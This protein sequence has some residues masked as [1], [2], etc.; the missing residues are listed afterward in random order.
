MVQAVRG[1][2]GIRATARAFRVAVST[3]QYWVARSAGQ[4]LDRV[5]FD[6]R[7][8]GRAVNRTP[9]RIE[10]HVLALREQLRRH[11]VLGEYGARA[12]GAALQEGRTTA[13]VPARATIHRIL[14]RHGALDGTHRQRR[15]PPPKGWYLPAVAAGRAELDSFDFIEDLKIAEGPLVSVL[16][17]TSLHGAV[18]GA[19]VMEQPSAQ[20]TVNTL[21]DRWRHLGL[22]SYAQFDNDTLFQGAHQWPDSVGRVTRLCL[23][24]GVTPVFAPP[25]EPGFQ[26][27][28]E[29]FNGLWQAKV[30]HRHHARS[31]ADLQ[32]VCDRYVAAHRAK[33]AAR[34]EAAPARRALSADFALDLRAPLRGTVVY[35][36]RT[37]EHG[38]VELLGYRFKVDPQWTHRLLRCEVDFTRHRIR[39]YALRRRQPAHQPLLCSFPYHRPDR[40]FQGK[41]QVYD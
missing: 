24:L 7:R 22:P 21:L 32:A 20:A 17:A 30:W 38:A 23:A 18:A 13:T 19:R 14:A 1:G 9:R 12:I 33:N 4:R 5:D 29:G 37:S 31:A 6:N 15:P 8:P 34:A 35:L 26:N 2:R 28:I 39:C 40:P 3:V 10:R 25:R 11:S 16:T 36:R 41:P 27:A